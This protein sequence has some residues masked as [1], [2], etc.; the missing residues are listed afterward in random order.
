MLKKKEEEEEKEVEE[1]EEEEEYVK[2]FYLAY[3]CYY[4]PK[5]VTLLWPLTEEL[6]NPCFAVCRDG[7]SLAYIALLRF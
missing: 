6:A 7:K 4:K 2:R 3:N 1:E 5:I